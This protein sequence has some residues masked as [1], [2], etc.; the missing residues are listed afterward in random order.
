MRNISVYGD[1]GAIRLQEVLQFVLQ[2]TKPARQSDTRYP[3]PLP[4]A[5]PARLLSVEISDFLK[6]AQRRNLRSA[7]IKAYARTLGLLQR[8]TGDIQAS[9]VAHTHIHKLW[10]V[11]TWA[12]EDCSSNPVHA[13]KS[14][15]QLIA[16]GKSG[17]RQRPAPLTLERH[18]R[19][20]GAFFNQLKT[21]GAI[22]HSPMDAFKQAKPDLM[23]KSEHDKRPFTDEELKRIFAP[24]TF[25]KWAKKYPHRWWAPM[26][27][28]HTGARVNEV[29]QLK[30]T[31]I[32]KKEGMWCMAIRKTADEGF[33]VDGRPASKQS[34]KNASSERTIPIP[35]ALIKAGFLGFYM[36]V[37]EAGCAYLFPQLIPKVTDKGLVAGRHSQALMNQFGLYLRKLGID[38]VAFHGFR[39]TLSTALGRLNV[40]PQ[41][42]ALITGHTVRHAVPELQAN[43]IHT[44]ETEDLA[45][46]KQVLELFKPDIE[47]PSYKRGQF[48]DQLCIKPKQ[49]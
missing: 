12:P 6:D 11:L 23:A 49:S 35:D 43:Y 44:S 13:N 16:E 38:D 45:K 5:T 10:D 28:L 18:R 15:D 39:H 7:T 17:N 29:A 34:L 14:A 48:K 32:I 42:L 22:A 8:V 25:P 21:A 30:T 27:G 24:E 46:K 33:Y 3:A 19:F 37:K 47:L 40:T 41:N 9:R 4:L 1:E 31:D 2:S 20:L 26:I 36:D